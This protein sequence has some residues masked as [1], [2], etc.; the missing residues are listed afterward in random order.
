MTNTNSAEHMHSR[1]PRMKPLRYR[2]KESEDKL[3]KYFKSIQNPTLRRLLFLLFAQGYS[4][5]KMTRKRIMQILDCSIRTSQDFMN[6]LN[7]ISE[8]LND[9]EAENTRIILKIQEEMTKK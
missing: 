5:T 8:I 3:K 4:R 7:S 6:A 2:D 9:I 1:K